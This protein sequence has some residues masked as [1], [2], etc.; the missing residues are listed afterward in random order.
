MIQID[1]VCIVRLMALSSTSRLEQD[2][3]RDEVF[4]KTFPRYKHKCKCPGMPNPAHAMQYFQE[5]LREREEMKVKVIWIKVNVDYYMMI[6]GTASNDVCQL[7]GRTQPWKE[8]LPS[9]FCLMDLCG[10][11]DPP[12]T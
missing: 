3:S 10:R 9:T 2:R 1:L 8:H 11:I 12:L 5:M 4:S 6:A 7:V